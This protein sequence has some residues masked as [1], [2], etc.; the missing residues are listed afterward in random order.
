[1]YGGGGGGSGINSTAAA[2]TAAAA[3]ATT[4]TVITGTKTTKTM[5][6]KN[7]VYCLR[8]PYALCLI[9]SIPVYFQAATTAKAAT[10]NINERMY[11]I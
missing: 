11:I 9:L 3:A 4:K 10:T 6:T 7:A 5:V 2:A 8:K 1:M